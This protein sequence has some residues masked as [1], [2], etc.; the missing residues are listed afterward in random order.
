[1]DEIIYIDQESI[2]KI[3]SEELS[4]DVLKC[5]SN[6]SDVAKPLIKSVKVSLSNIEKMLYSTPAFI[7]LIK[8]SIPKETFQAVLTD[9][10]NRKLAEGSLKLMTR[11]DGSLMANLVNP[12]TKKIVSAISLEKINLTPEISQAM[13]NYTTQMQLAKIAEQIQLI[14]ISVEE[15]RKGQ[16]YDRLASAYSCKQKFL[17]AMVIRN[18]KLKELALLRVASDSEDSRNLLMLSQNVSLEFIKNQPESFWGKLLPTSS[19]DKMDG[20]INEIRENLYAVNLVS[21]VEAMAYFEMGEDEAAQQSLQ[22]YGEYIQKTYLD[23]EG[24]VQRLD[25]LDPSTEN[26]WSKSLPDIKKRITELP[27]NVEQKMLEGEKYGEE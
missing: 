4:Y 27:F 22:Y 17:Q 2:D 18:P 23:I 25:M 7:N 19:P 10:Q 8:S 20:R 14:Q 3:T 21:F 16:E 6:I 24:L 26:Y 12:R 9:E 1:M 15:V 11:K 5:F 13:T